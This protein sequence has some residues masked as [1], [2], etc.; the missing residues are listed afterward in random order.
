MPGGKQSPRIPLPRHW[1][2]HVGSAVPQVISLAQYAA[3]TARRWA[4]DSMNCRVR[5]AAQLD[6]ARQEI[7]LLR[8]TIRMQ[9]YADTCRVPR[10]STAP[11]DRKLTV[12]CTRCA[13]FIR[14]CYCV[15]SRPV[16]APVFRSRA[17]RRSCGRLNVYQHDSG[18]E[19][20]MPCHERT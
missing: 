19:P 4:V 3:V 1:A 5:L 18:R 13:Y 15:P 2:K 6:R 16:A 7:A 12:R 20:H 8:E 9:T 17:P 11:A 14:F 10:P